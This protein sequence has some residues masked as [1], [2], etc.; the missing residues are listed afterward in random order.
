MNLLNVTLSGQG[1]RRI[2]AR[3][4]KPAV[5]AALLLALLA[6][7]AFAGVVEKKASLGGFDGFGRYGL[8]ACCLLEPRHPWI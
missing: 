2:L 4:L 1:P 6:S 8:Y 3:L 5:L 7:S